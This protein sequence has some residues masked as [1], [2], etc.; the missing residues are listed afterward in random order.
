TMSHR[1]LPL[2]CA[3]ALG[4]STLASQ[5]VLADGSPAQQ[6]AEEAA[7][8]LDISKFLKPRSDAHSQN[9]LFGGTSVHQLPIKEARRYELAG[10][11]S[12]DVTDPY[13]MK[14]T[15]ASEQG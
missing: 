3:L 4:L 5:A 10:V 12:F 7:G 11:A 13:T 1:A 2:A 9:F 14:A 15:L 6:R 8:K